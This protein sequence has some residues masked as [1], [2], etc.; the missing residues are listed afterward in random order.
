[1]F[2]NVFFI[3]CLCILPMASWADAAVQLKASLDRIATLQGN[4]SQLLKDGQGQLLQKSAGRFTLKR[5]GYFYWQ[6]E[7]PFE[8]VVIGTP[9]KVW[10]YDPDLEQVTVRKNL[11]QQDSPAAIISGDLDRLKTFFGIES[12]Q[13]QGQKY[14]TYTLTPINADNS[15]KQVTLQFQKNQ[16]V[17][18]SFL[19][20]LDQTTDI[21]FTDTI[22]NK[23]VADALFHFDVPDGVDVI[24]DE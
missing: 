17:A 8:Q 11:Q 10:V 9:D 23:P 21:T 14:T 12:E 4:F 18:L 22:E 24:L 19:D 20:K 1:M 3:G 16:L 2:K 13:K 5:P 7:A 6:S 15:F